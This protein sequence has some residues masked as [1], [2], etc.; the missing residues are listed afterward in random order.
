MKTKIVYVLV[1]SENDFFY[2]QTIIS[3]TSC[4][5]WNDS[6]QIWLVTDDRTNETLKGSRSKIDTL[7]TE[8]VIVPFDPAIGNKERSRRIKTS[9]REIINGDYLYIDSDTVICAPLN[10]VDSF[11]FPI[12]M[13]WDGNH[14]FDKE[15]D[16]VVQER[17]SK[18]GYNVSNEPEYFNGGVMYVKDSEISHCFCK[19]WNEEYLKSEAI[20]LI[21]DQP[22]LMIT[23]MKFNHL[24]HAIDGG[25]NCQLFMGGFN[26]L[27]YAKILHVFN[28]FGYVNCFWFSSVTFMRQVK[29]DGCVREEEIENLR[30]PKRCFQGDIV[31][32]HDA[33]VLFYRSALYHVFFHSKKMFRCLEIVGKI[34]LKLERMLGIQK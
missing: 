5:I 27:S 33:D 7:I 21:Y 3:L 10:D 9:L 12:G 32:L 17:A 18:L 23:N 4:R 8:K 13:V 15:K 11:D 1:S 25:Y 30:F 26:E 19:T 29:E 16:Y 6:A 24:I 31:L 14:K 28:A 2:E 34:F 20:G 22:P